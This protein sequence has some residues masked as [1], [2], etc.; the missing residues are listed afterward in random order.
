MSPGE[1][2][3][4]LPERVYAFPQLELSRFGFF[5]NGLLAAL[6]LL[7]LPLKNPPVL[8]LESK[9]PASNPTSPARSVVPNPFQPKP[10]S[11]ASFSKTRFI[12]FS[13]AVYTAS[14]AY[15]H[16]TLEVR[17]NPWW[18][19]TDPLARPFARMPAP[20]YYATGLAMATGLNWLSWKMGHSHRWRKNGIAPRFLIKI[21]T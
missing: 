15:M 16:Q 9:Q 11:Q 14:I 18:Y 10:K 2:C 6:R 4:N 21:R 12:L 19:E 20:A 1:G 5:Q 13:A 3:R 7:S 17:K 8:L